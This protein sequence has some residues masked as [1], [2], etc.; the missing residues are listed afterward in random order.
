M[1]STLVQMPPADWQEAKSMTDVARFDEEP[2]GTCDTGTP[3]LA[4][5]VA[6]ALF[7][8]LRTCTPAGC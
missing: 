6:I 8:V 2:Q 5:I 1:A 4:A 7:G 3:L